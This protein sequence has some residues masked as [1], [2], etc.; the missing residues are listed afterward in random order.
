[1]T[2][3]VR[4]VE[5]ARARGNQEP[6]CAVGEAVILLTPPS[7]P[8]LRRLLKGEGGAA[9]WQSRR[10]LNPTEP[11]G[12]APLCAGGRLGQGW[13]RGAWGQLGELGG[14]G[15]GPKYRGG[16]GRFG[17]CNRG[18]AS[19]SALSARLGDLNL[20]LHPRARSDVMADLIAVRARPPG[21]RSCQ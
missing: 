5:L 17:N 20:H 10:R 2:H 18:Q 6:A 7:P 14:G 3:R 1:M 15:V 16:G 8:I 9:E 13:T 11:A 4:Q 12:D 21:A 19:L